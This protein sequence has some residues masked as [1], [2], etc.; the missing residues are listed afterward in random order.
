MNFLI[1]YMFR[2][3]S[4]NRSRYFQIFTKLADM[5]HNV[6]VIQPP[7]M[8]STDTGFIES[9]AKLPKSLFLHDTHINE[10]FWNFSL[11]LNKV[12]K[13][14]FYS[15]TANRSIRHMI[16]DLNI[17]AVILY[18]LSHYPLS[19]IRHCVKIYDIGDD[20]IPMLKRELGMFNNPVAIALAK[21]MLQNMQ[22]NCDI[23]T[24]ISR[25]LCGNNHRDAYVIPNG[26]NIEDAIRGSGNEIKN[27][28]AKPII[29]FVGSFEYYIDF[30]IIL[31]T[32][33]RSRDFTFL[34]V[35]GGRE[36]ARVKEKTQK[37]KLTNVHLTGGKPHP[38]VMRYIDAMD[39]CINPFL[40]NPL[41]HGASPIKL[42]EYLSFK[43]PVISTRL[44]GVKMIDEGFLYY[45]DDDDE[46]AGAITRILSNQEEA[47]I[48]AEKGFKAIKE[49]YTWDRIA[50]RLLELVESKNN[51]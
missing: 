3:K 15:M 42:F 40:K 26:V 41:T 44:H 30:D 8:R 45:A 28:Y 47:A 31:K 32:A 49:K 36:F 12:I 29:G 10:F 50:R 39:I 51:A 1:P 43:K 27:N 22:H 19:K 4:L 48:K 37:L 2:W 16:K 23:I 46:M 9:E 33:A 6:H 7:P 24:A 14:S 25:V 21:K 17:D 20:I 5:G 13:K 18:N 38:E 34:L 11:P 35:G